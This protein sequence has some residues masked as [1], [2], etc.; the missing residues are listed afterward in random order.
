MFIFELQDRK[1]IDFL[2]PYMRNITLNNIRR[3]YRVKLIYSTANHQT[4]KWQEQELS[5]LIILDSDD[6][7]P[8][9]YLINIIILVIVFIF[10]AMISSVF[11]SNRILSAFLL[12]LG[13][14]SLTGI[15][16]YGLVIALTTVPVPGSAIKIKD[17]IKAIETGKPLIYIDKN[18]NIKTF[19]V[20]K[21]TKIDY[22]EQL[23]KDVYLLVKKT[24]NNITYA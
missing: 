23:V 21:P 13:S 24:D 18:R 14:V 5:Y 1:L 15:I 9:N 3:T 22:V 8:K 11:P 19:R 17:V 4:M 7:K 10:T 20:I 16:Y 12:F 2:W 6:R